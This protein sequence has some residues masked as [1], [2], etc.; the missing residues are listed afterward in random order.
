MKRVRQICRACTD[1][2]LRIVGSSCFALLIFIVLGLILVVLVNR[3]TQ[4]VRIE[5]NTGFVEVKILPGMPTVWAL[6]GARLLENP[7]FGQATSETTNQS[8]LRVPDKIANAQGAKI[9]I[10]AEIELRAFEGGK[11]GCPDTVLARISLQREDVIVELEPL[12]MSKGDSQTSGS[13]CAKNIAPLAV[14]DNG[15]G[16]RRGLIL[17]ALLRLS[18]DQIDNGLT[19]E[20][21][22]DLRIGSDVSSSRQPLLKSGRLALWEVRDRGS[23]SSLF[24]GRIFEIE[25]R[26]LGLGDKLLIA[27]RLRDRNKEDV[28]QGFARIV[29][30]GTTA[31]MTVFVATVAAWAQLV[32]PFGAPESPRAH[33][34]NLFLADELLSVLSTV[35]GTLLAIRGSLSRPSESK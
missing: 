6:G 17:P 3:G 27:E 22:G 31:E 28:P 18:G 35:L 7:Q 14:L 25:Q 23:L 13:D 29:Q 34:I 2:F 12:S 16:V 30:G 21:R 33:W 5:A 1:S 20:L 4:H 19:L 8:S 15:S 9:P 11:N 32:R 24:F 26:E 10:D